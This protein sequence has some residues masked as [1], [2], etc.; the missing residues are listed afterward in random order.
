MEGNNACLG[1]TEL[2]AVLQMLNSF[3]S[4]CHPTFPEDLQPSN[5]SKNFTLSLQL[6][7]STA[8]SLLPHLLGN[9]CFSGCRFSQDERQGKTQSKSHKDLNTTD[10]NVGLTEHFPIPTELRD[11]RGN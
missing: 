3:F 10:N 4:Q 6:N 9:I 5:E 1:S 11:V 2:S 7:L 8:H